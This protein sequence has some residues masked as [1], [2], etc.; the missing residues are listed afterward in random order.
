MEKMSLQ[1]SEINKLKNMVVNLENTYKLAQI[2]A[3]TH[4]KKYIILNEELKKLQNE[5]TLKEQISYVKN[6]LWNKIIEAINDV[7]RSIQV[8][9]EQRDL[10]KVVLA[11]IQKTN[12]ELDIKIEQAIEL[13]KFLNRKNYQ[14]IEELYITDRNE[15]ILEIRKVS[16]K[17]N[18]MKQ[19]EEKCENMNIA[20]TKFMV[21]FENLRQISLPRILV[22]NDK[23]MP[24]E[25]YNKNI[26][27]F[28]KEKVKKTG[29]QGTP[30]GKVLLG[31]F[32]DLFY[33]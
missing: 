5:L 4:E 31:S 17:K 6:H 33:L 19:L 2:N 12:D 25:D 23:L 14:E 21:K 20:I 11:E 22:I 27:E 24:Q 9:F 13:I 3:K 32:E 8:I 29:G 30:I 15:T 18:L 10:L 7:W 1:T 26:R 16:T 28:A